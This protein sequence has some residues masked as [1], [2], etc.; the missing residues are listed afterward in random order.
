MGSFVLLTL[1]NR[2]DAY[3]SAI[4]RE[5]AHIPDEA[6]RSGR[7]AVLKVFDARPSLYFT[8]LFATKF[9]QAAKANLRREMSHLCGGV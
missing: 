8:P 6:F 5:Y 4:R 9:N 1:S 2:Y 7:L 3:A